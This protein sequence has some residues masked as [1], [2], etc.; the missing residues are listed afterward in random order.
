MQVYELFCLNALATLK[1]LRLYLDYDF[2]HYAHE[3]FDDRTIKLFLLYWCEF[4]MGV[5]IILLTYIK[6][7]IICLYE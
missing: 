3:F 5:C 7:I 2:F 6:C 4:G 1:C